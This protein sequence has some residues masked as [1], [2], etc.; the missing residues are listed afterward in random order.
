M[1]IRLMAYNDG[2][3]QRMCL[4][5]IL[6]FFNILILHH[7]HLVIQQQLDFS[8]MVFIAKSSN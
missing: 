5:Y 3:V 7:Y 2:S 8:S 6:Y 1:A 4:N